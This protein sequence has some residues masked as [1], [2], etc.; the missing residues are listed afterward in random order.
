MDPRPRSISIPNK[1]GDN[2]VENTINEMVTDLIAPKNLV[3]YISD[4][5]EV[6]STFAV[7]FVTAIKTKNKTG[8]SVNLKVIENMNPNIMGIK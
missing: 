1:I 3:P 8:D 6:M 7:P 4:H 5:V 2:D